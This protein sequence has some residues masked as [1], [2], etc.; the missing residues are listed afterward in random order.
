MCLL[1]HILLKRLGIILKPKVLYNRL[2][3]VGSNQKGINEAPVED[4]YCEN[5]AK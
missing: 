5:K 4:I 3:N 1:Q 2:W